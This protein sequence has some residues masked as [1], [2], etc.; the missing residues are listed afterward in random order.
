MEEVLKDILAELRKIRE[1]LESRGEKINPTEIASK[2]KEVVKREID[3]TT[4]DY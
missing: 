3:A 1:L 4:I 2:I